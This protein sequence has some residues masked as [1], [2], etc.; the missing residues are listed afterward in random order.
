MA[1]VW[2]IIVAITKLDSP[3]DGVVSKTLIYCCVECL[4]SKLA[5]LVPLQGVIGAKG[6]GKPL[7]RRMLMR[8]TFGSPE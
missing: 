2:P 5:Y 3:S 8:E 6:T 4:V 1:H 7:R